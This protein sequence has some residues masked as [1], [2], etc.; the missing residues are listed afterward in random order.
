MK[1]LPLKNLTSGFGAVKLMRAAGLKS[2]PGPD[3]GGPSS[4]VHE[5]G[6]STARTGLD[7]FSNASMTDGNGSRISPE[8]LNPTK[9]VSNV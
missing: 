5:D 9:S 1:C 3:L 2:F 7:V 4:I 6:A 8:K